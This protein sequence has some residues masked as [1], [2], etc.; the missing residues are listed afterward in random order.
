MATKGSLVEIQI[1]DGVETVKMPSI[2]GQT[3]QSAK[4]QY[5]NR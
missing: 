3:L 2:K 5:W 1:S 4:K